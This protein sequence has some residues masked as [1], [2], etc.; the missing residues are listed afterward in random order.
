[1]T[2]VELPTALSHSVLCGSILMALRCSPAPK[3]ELPIPLMISSLLLI[4]TI[5]EGF[6]NYFS[7]QSSTFYRWGGELHRGLPKP[8]PSRASVKIFFSR[9]LTSYSHLYCL[10]DQLQSQPFC[11]SGPTF[12]NHNRVRTSRLYKMRVTRLVLLAASCF[13]YG[14]TRQQLFGVSATSEILH[15][16]TRGLPVGMLSWPLQHH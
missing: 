10:Q 1:M 6:T 4:T 13:V 3:T 15:A 9:Y 5:P 7:E 11:K 16:Y 8:H 12:W 14:T 2:G